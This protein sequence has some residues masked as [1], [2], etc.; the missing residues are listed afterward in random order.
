MAKTAVFTGFSRVSV[1]TTE[2]PSERKAR[3]E[4][5]HK[6]LMAKLDGKAIKLTV[7]FTHEQLMAQIESNSALASEWAIQSPAEY[8]KAVAKR[9]AAF[10]A[11]AKKNGVKKANA[12]YPNGRDGLPYSWA[13][14]SKARAAK[15]A[16]WTKAEAVNQQ[17]IY[18]SLADFYK[19]ELAKLVASV[20]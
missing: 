12:H 13:V 15:D 9:Q 14:G 4:R 10:D 16:G 1:T 17:A 7:T 3:K 18:L 19:A 8:A 11:F 20:K 6:E 5:E 2:T